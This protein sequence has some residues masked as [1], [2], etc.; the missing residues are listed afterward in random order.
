MESQGVGGVA[1]VQP[2]AEPQVVHLVADEEI[3]DGEMEAPEGE[4][5]ARAELKRTL[6]R[7]QRHGG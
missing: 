3:A 4:E 6:Q 7:R 2:G 1:A 5:A